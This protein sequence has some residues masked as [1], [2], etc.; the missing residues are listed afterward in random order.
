MNTTGRGF[1]P[2]PGQ[3]RAALGPRPGAATPAQGGKRSDRSACSGRG[4]VGVAERLPAW[5]Q[6]LVTEGESAI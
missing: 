1:G 5:L 6:T 2:V 3:T 4:Q